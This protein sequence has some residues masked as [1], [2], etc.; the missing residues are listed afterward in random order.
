MR[1]PDADEV[2]SSQ[3]SSVSREVDSLLDDFDDFED[4]PDFVESDVGAESDVCVAET[5]P[6]PVHVVGNDF[7][8]P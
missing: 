6:K 7:V 5:D 8:Y 3:G 2:V 4:V 1:D